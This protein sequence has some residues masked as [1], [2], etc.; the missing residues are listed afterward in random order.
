MD[1]ATITVSPDPI[2]AA[3]VPS[4]MAR[5][6]EARRL[7]LCGE[8]ERARRLC[9]ESV[10]GWLPWICRDPDL[11]Q[12]AISTLFHAH[13]F[14]QLRRLLAAAH[15]HRV[16]FVLQ[17]PVAPNPRHGITATGLRDGTTVFEFADDLFEH[18]S[19]EH[20]VEAWSRQLVA[21][22]PENL[23]GRPERSVA[24]DRPSAIALGR[25]RPEGATAPAGS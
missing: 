17:P 20:L 5:L 23:I 2:D 6:K 15:G 13:G 16:R 1:M 24:A 9:A 22:Q 21:R 12:T 8:R 7:A 14:E 19:R 18:P 10:L 4:I 11:L 3:P 25:T